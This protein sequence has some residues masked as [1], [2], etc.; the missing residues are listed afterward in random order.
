MDVSAKQPNYI[1]CKFCEWKT[2]KWRGP[3]NGPSKAFARLRAHIKLEHN[4]KLDDI[5]QGHEEFAED[6]PFNDND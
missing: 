5:L 3:K 6:N 4:D 2:P 1:R